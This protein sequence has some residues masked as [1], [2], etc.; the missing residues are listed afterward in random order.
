[1]SAV[2]VQ[3]RRFE[4]SRT[5]TIELPAHWLPFQVDELQETVVV[6]AYRNGNA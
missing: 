5:E 2:K 1:M 3:I 6:W 4:F